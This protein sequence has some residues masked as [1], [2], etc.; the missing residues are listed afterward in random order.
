MAGSVTI[1]ASFGAGGNIIGPAVAD[2][3]GLPFVDRA[4]P[5]EV[6]QRLAIPLQ[7]AEAQDEK[8]PST[9]SRLARAYAFATTPGGPE[10]VAES[11]D[12][13]DRFREETEEILRRVADTTGGILLGRAGMVVLRGRP[14]VLSVRL[15]GPREARI[16]QVVRDGLGETE[17]RSVQKDVDDAREGYARVFY[18]ARQSDP[19]FYHVILDSTALS[20]ETCTDL[21]VMAARARLGFADATR[22]PG[23]TASSGGV[24]KTAQ[25][26]EGEGPHL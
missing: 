17:A 4:I 13:P 21:I 6:A 3:L 19:S 1:S 23:D 10:P 20:F 22:G 9:W 5:V 11:L 16:S 14:D 2:R 15:D 26:D 24:G 18:R 8:A 12:H 25:G 7:S